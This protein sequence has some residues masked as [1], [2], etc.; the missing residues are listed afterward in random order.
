M[1]KPILTVAAVGVAGFALWKVASVLLLPLVGA[2]LG[3]VFTILKFAA[4][5]GLIWLAYWLIT[6]KKDKG[7]EAPAT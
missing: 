6:R 7:G 4:I 1:H 2:L 5:G 3:L